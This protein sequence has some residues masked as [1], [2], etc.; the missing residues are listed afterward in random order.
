MGRVVQG[1]TLRPGAP[2]ETPFSA[3]TAQ[4]RVGGVS[5]PSPRVREAV[6]GTHV[7]HYTT[8]AAALEHILPRAASPPGPLLSDA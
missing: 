6:P 2:W 3:V 4:G 5:L 8:M 1:V 7:Y